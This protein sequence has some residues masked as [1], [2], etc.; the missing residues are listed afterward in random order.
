MTSSLSQSTFRHWMKGSSVFLAFVL[1]SS[2]GLHSVDLRHMH[3]G[4]SGGD[5]SH[6]HAQPQMTTGEYIHAA[7]KK[8][9]ASLPSIWSLGADVATVFLQTTVLA[10]ILLFSMVRFRVHH[11]RVGRIYSFVSSLFG[12]GVLHSKLCDQPCTI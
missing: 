8:L 6:S 3:P 5:H 11:T 9:F 10:C 4:Q 1:V 12:S 2:F 7:D